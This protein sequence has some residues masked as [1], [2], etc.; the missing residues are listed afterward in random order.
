MPRLEAALSG[1]PW[2]GG[3][4]AVTD[5]PP[6]PQYYTCSCILAFVACSVFLRMSLELKVVLLTVALV[7]Y[8]VLFN[9]SPCWQWDCCSHSL[10]NLTKTNGTLRWGPRRPSRPRSTAAPPFGSAVV[11]SCGTVA[12]GPVWTGRLWGGPA[13][14]TLAMGQASDGLGPLRSE[15]ERDSFAGSLG[16]APGRTEASWVIRS[17]CRSGGGSGGGL[18]SS[19]GP[20][21]HLC[22]GGPESSGKHC[23]LTPEGLACGCFWGLSAPVG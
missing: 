2:S 19:P 8:L 3:C 9:I 5:I 14:G 22:P 20:L 4:L 1:D 10:A 12:L 23:C 15:L 21:L 6:P 11:S 16:D 13:G 7:A 17:L 18:S